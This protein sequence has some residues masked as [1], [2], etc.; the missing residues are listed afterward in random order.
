MGRCPACSEWNTLVEELTQRRQRPRSLRTAGP[1][2]PVSEVTSCAL[3]PV[4]TGVAELDRVM[5]GGLIP[6]SA[7]VIGGEP[8]IGKSTLLLQAAGSMAD[9]N[10]RVLFVCAEESVQQVRLRAERLGTLAAELFLLSETSLPE[11][12]A[13]VGQL[14]PAMLVIDSIQTV[15]DPDSG[16]AAGSVTQV[17]DCAQ[18]LVQQAKESGMVCMIVG[19]V[20]KDGALAGPRVLEHLVD[21]VLSFEGERHH[22][23]RLLRVIKHRFGSTQELGL[24]E[25][26]GSGLA[27]VPD[28]SGLFLADRREKTTGSVVVP[29]VQGHRP[30]LIELQALVTD[31]KLATPR[32]SVHGLDGGRLAL[33]LAVLAERAG[34]RIR[35]KDVY[36]L[37]VGGVKVA[38]PG[39]DLALAL[40]V[41]S[42]AADRAVPPDVVACG[43]IGL[44]GELRQVGQIERRLTEAG[45]LGFC[46]AVLPRRAPDPGG[47]IE[48]LR[49]PSLA[50]AIE[51][52]G[53]R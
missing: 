52:L 47:S 22:A 17:R 38:E 18:R 14:T 8:G 41:A 43:E 40:A 33:I 50:G 29:T 48:V 16:S 28:A 26:T 15:H 1:P 11:I 13:A 51:M 10:R 25:M 34:I 27:A 30:M 3:E 46:R 6:G 36:S 24:F 19:H 23:L 42:A 37:A 20:T 5:Q 21:T 12:L 9:Q 32:R 39:A 31:S 35:D 7:T 4:P 45:R 44:G 53:L 2:V 49:V